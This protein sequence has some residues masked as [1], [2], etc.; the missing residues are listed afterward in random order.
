VAA[1][2]QSRAFR[3]TSDALNFYS[4]VENRS[5]IA[6]L[7]A[8]WLVAS[9]VR[10]ERPTVVELKGTVLPGPE[11]RHVPIWGEGLLLC[12]GVDTP[13]A[14]ED[15]VTFGNDEP[16]PLPRITGNAKLASRPTRSHLQ[17]IP[18]WCRCH[19]MISSRPQE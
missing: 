12:D 3:N 6:D 2:D 9:G 11:I 1:Y 15:G 14:L 13:D 18:G 19:H 10:T 5:G 7:L 4:L 8:G 16:S 17:S